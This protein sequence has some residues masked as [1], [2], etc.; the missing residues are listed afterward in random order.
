MG[1]STKA[2]SSLGNRTISIN[3]DQSTDNR[4]N[5]NNRATLDEI[6]AFE[7]MRLNQCV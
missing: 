6:N 5:E 2:R 4:F 1:K 7:A 3:S